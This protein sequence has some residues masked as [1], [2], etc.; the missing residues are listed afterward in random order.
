MRRMYSENQLKD[1]IKEEV[2]GGQLENAKPIYYHPIY[3]TDNTSGANARIT[4]AILNNSEE[5]LNTFTKLS[6]E[7]QRLMNLGATIQCNG[8]FDKSSATYNASVMEKAADNYLLYG[9]DYQGNRTTINITSLSNSTVS[10]GV[11]KIN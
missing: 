9:Y 3:I 1:V 6:N 8:Y 5:K 7:L 4:L 11:N 2:E 10:D